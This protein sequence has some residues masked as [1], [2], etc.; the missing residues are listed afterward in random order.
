MACPWVILSKAASTARHMRYFR[1]QL[2][3]TNIAIKQIVRILLLSFAPCVLASW[4]AI[5]FLR[6]IPC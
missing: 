4:T 2:S 1:S 5:V 3:I 6:E